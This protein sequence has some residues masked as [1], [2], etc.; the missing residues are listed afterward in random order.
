MPE[1]QEE[2][3]VLAAE[4]N[5][6]AEEAV[7]DILKEEATCPSDSAAS[8]LNISATSP[9]RECGETDAQDGC[10][11]PRTP[12]MDVG[13]VSR[14]LKLH[15]PVI[16]KLAERTMPLCDI[17]GLTTGGIIEFD[18]PADSELDLMINNK[19]VGHGQAVK[20]GENFG[21]RVTSIGSIRSRIK[22]MGR[23]TTR[24]LSETTTN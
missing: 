18:R 8:P 16:V 11:A 21:L 20:A 9:Q 3:N 19:C 15:V 12:S 17:V 10:S 7:A 1:S 14:I 13:Q 24:Q 2:V 23:E 5:A 22:A 6:L 4:V